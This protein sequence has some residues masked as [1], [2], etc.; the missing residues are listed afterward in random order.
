MTIDE[1]V[2][3]IREFPSRKVVLTGGEPLIHAAMPELAHR[4]RRLGFHVTVETAGFVYR[5]I[6]CDLLSLS[7][8]LPKSI[9]GK[10]TFRPAIIKRLI[11]P[12]E[13]Y[14]VKFVVA[15]LDQVCQAADLVEKYP[16]IRTEN[17]L[18]MP[19]ARTA[20]EYR[21]LAPKI[22]RWA[23]HNNLRFCPRLHLEL[24]IK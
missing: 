16:F 8:K 3:Q 5:K 22:A 2:A 12:A 23:L 4:L 19:N 10:V 11:A 18:L 14:Q 7:P 17:V 6:R 24:G 9:P 21:R 13:D 1:I 15:N 20:A